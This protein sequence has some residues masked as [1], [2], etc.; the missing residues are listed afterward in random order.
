MRF[1]LTV[2]TIILLSLGIVVRGVETDAKRGLDFFRG[3]ADTLDLRFE[4]EELRSAAINA[5]KGLEKYVAPLGDYD[6]KNPEPVIEALEKLRYEFAHLPLI[7]LGWKACSNAIATTMRIEEA[8]AAPRQLLAEVRARRTIDDFRAIGK[9]IDKFSTFAG[10][11]F[12]QIIKTHTPVLLKFLGGFAGGFDSS[13]RWKNFVNMSANEDAA[14]RSIAD[15]MQLMGNSR[16][17]VLPELF[18]LNETFSKLTISLKPVLDQQPNLAQIFRVWIPKIFANKDF[19]K[20]TI[21]RAGLTNKFVEAA[22]L[23]QSNPEEAGKR[24]GGLFYE[25]ATEVKDDVD[26]SPFVAGLAGLKSI[27]LSVIGWK[28]KLTPEFRKH[29]QELTYANPKNSTYYLTVKQFVTS[30]VGIFE[31]LKHVNEWMIKPRHHFKHSIKFLLEKGFNEDM[32]F[33]YQKVPLLLEDIF[34]SAGLF[35]NGSGIQAGDLMYSALTV[36]GDLFKEDGEGENAV[37]FINAFFDP[38]QTLSLKLEVNSDIIKDV[39]ERMLGISQESSY[40]YNG[41][42]KDAFTDIT[43]LD[44]NSERFKTNYILFQA[45]KNIIPR[46]SKMDIQ[47]R[48][49]VWRRLKLVYKIFLKKGCEGHAGVEFRK[50]AEDL[51]AQQPPKD[52]VVYV[53]AFLEGFTHEPVIATWDTMDMSEDMSDNFRGLED[54]WNRYASNLAKVV[55]RLTKSLE[56]ISKKNF[57]KIF[58]NPNLQRILLTVN[59][60]LGMMTERQVEKTIEKRDLED[61]IS[62]ALDAYKVDITLAGAIFREVFDDLYETRM[63][64]K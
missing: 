28:D 13:F 24:L 41:I 7:D 18:K 59:T 57:A 12:G 63:M 38:N 27:D 10:I 19:V 54:Y 4:E 52:V 39:K 35:L 62:A 32:D 5:L 50:L 6:E 43:K 26:L 30:L 17:N 14:N 11:Q 2:A 40:A 42:F 29:I 8:L 60:E 1:E 61:K 23:Y 37:E 25:L 21:E 15:S 36:F 64:D 58:N 9:A 47:F 49:S 53:P 46:L 33:Y 51:Y 20:S 44:S 45:S 22:S 3:I 48:S 16:E 56:E 31:D 34:T 55:L